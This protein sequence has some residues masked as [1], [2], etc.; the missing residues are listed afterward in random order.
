[1]NRRNSLTSVFIVGVLSTT[2]CA[3]NDSSTESI[4]A[5]GAEA[6]EGQGAST[7]TALVDRAPAGNALP[8]SSIGSSHVTVDHDLGSVEPPSPA[9]VGRPLGQYAE[10]AAGAG[11]HG[12]SPWSA[13]VVT[14]PTDGTVYFNTWD[15]ATSTPSIH[16]LSDGLSE[17][18]AEGGFNP[19]VSS[20]GQLAFARLRTD[21]IGTDVVV[22]PSGGG[23]VGNDGDRVWVPGAPAARETFPVAWAGSALVSVAVAADTGFASTTIKNDDSTFE[24]SGL[25]LA[26]SPDGRF[27]MLVE[28]GFESYFTIIE[29]STLRVVERV[30][31]PALLSALQTPADLEGVPADHV[32]DASEP[33]PI[34]TPNPGFGVW[35]GD[36]IAYVSAGSITRLRVAET[37]GGLSV[38]PLAI[39][40][41]GGSWSASVGTGVIRA[42]D[43]GREFIVFVRATDLG[44]LRE[45]PPP[46]V[47]SG[48]DD[49]KEHAEAEAAEFRDATQSSYHRCVTGVPESCRTDP[50]IGDTDI[51]TIENNSR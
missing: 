39:E 23:A 50:S 51:T 13:D 4:V 28:Y 49:L 35:S 3:E 45:S 16:R 25:P 7:P 33:T 30:E 34:F 18:V 27:I 12:L 8:A 38:E 21:G 46:S 6:A 1:M 31:Y 9:P 17:K 40:P 19:V 15:I 42:L 10:L 41:L 14:D 24:S 29:S 48:V 43:G 44:V 36:T 26:L 37:I 2:A 11:P 5:V 47:I 20:N 22:R 32:P